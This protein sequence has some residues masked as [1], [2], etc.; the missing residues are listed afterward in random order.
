MLADSPARNR[1]RGALL[2]LRTKPVSQATRGHYRPSPKSEVRASTRSVGRG[3]PQ[4]G[5]ADGLAATRYQA[6]LLV[7]VA[8]LTARAFY[9]CGRTA[10]LAALDC[11]GGGA[12]LTAHA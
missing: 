2:A 12:A 7:K 4:R 11:V 5:A 8:V 9:P 1:A 3:A 10:R 6:A